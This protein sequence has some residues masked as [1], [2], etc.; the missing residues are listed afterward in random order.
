MKI[1]M[2]Y[3]EEPLKDKPCRRLKRKAN[4]EVDDSF[5]AKKTKL[6]IKVTE[7][8][9]TKPC[10]KRAAVAESLDEPSLKRIK[11]VAYLKYDVCI[12]LT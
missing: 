6:G 3:P 8:A 11:V 4:I 12:V 9:K 10:K 1:S 2:A 5:T 7:T